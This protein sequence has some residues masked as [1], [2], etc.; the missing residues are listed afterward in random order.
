MSAAGA[1]GT[2]LPA[3]ARTQHL[4]PYTPPA[5]SH[6]GQLIDALTLLIMVFGALYTPVLLGW[7]SPEARAQAAA[8]APDWP[9]LGQSPVAAAQ[10][11]KLGYD[12]ARAA[13]LVRKR[14]EYRIEPWGLAI[15]T[16]VLLG[17]F[18]FVLVISEREYREMIRERFGPARDEPA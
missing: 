12:P 9:G 17:Y 8:A 6:A 14:F 18:A 7:T 3:A 13:P 15:T 11:Q 10:W 4:R 1:D 5:Q 16:L 2:A